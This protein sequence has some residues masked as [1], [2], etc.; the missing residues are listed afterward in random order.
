MESNHAEER[1][2]NSAGDCTGERLLLEKNAKSSTSTLLGEQPTTTTLLEEQP[3]QQSRIKR[4][5]P[6]QEYEQMSYLLEI[7]PPLGEH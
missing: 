2:N 7:M 5:Q 1:H 6:C 4:I 3:Q